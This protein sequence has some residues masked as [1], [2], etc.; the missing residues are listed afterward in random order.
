MPPCGPD[1]PPPL[2]G[3]QAGNLALHVCALGGELAL[4]VFVCLRA[5]G[6]VA[7]GGAPL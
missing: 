1:R 7:M 3:P 2:T 6:R 4:L 5:G